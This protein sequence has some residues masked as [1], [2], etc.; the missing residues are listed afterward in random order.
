MSLNLALP[1]HPLEN[2]PVSSMLWVHQ[3]E[4]DWCS[5]IHSFFKWVDRDKTSLIDIV[6]WWWKLD[7]VKL[8][9]FL[10]CCY[11]YST[12]VPVSSRSALVPQGHHRATP[13]FTFIGSPIGPMF[14]SLLPKFLSN[15]SGFTLL[16]LPDSANK[17]TR[18]PIKFECQMNNK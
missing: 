2:L 8:C 16:L 17:N 18:W 10:V 13:P 5:W 9:S 7:S 3:Q 15:Q 1:M 4:Q 12:L 11:F 6:S 14:D